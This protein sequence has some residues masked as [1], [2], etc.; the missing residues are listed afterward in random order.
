MGKT[1]IQ[2]RFNVPGKIGWATMEAPAFV[3]LLYIMYSLP[4]QEE[5]EKLPFVNWVMAGLFVSYLSRT[6]LATPDT[7]AKML[8]PER[9][10]I[11]STALSSHHFS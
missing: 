7:R 3:M 5:I 1:S 8:N 2:S 4:K 11:T 10:F 6:C 9:Q